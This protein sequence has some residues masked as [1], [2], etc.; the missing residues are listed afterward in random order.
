MSSPCVDAVIYLFDWSMEGG[1]EVR[2]AHVMLQ[3]E[4]SAA[5]LGKVEP[6]GRQTIS[7]PLILNRLH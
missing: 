1:V 5:V 3:C 2:R 6:T 4:L 7:T